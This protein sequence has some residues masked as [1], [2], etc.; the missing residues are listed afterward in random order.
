M[1]QANFRSIYVHKMGLIPVWVHTNWNQLMLNQIWLATWPISYATVAFR[2]DILNENWQVFSPFVLI[3][4]IRTKV[5]AIIA[6]L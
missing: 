1:A 3:A 2:Y 6:Q 5:T 4:T